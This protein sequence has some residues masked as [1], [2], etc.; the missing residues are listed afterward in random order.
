MN[1]T[2]APFKT[3]IAEKSI[4]KPL[5]TTDIFSS[6]DR[7][8]GRENYMEFVVVA[9]SLVDSSETSTYGETYETN[10]IY[11]VNFSKL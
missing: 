4:P 5:T 2:P 8:S 3:V 7:S 10:P 1:V 11:K 6:P 9:Q